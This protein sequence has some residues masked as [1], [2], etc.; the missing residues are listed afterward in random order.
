MSEDNY[1]KIDNSSPS[2]SSSIN[3]DY[4]FLNK[5]IQRLIENKTIKNP[6]K[7][8]FIH[9][10]Y[11]GDGFVRICKITFPPQ[12]HEFRIYYNYSIYKMKIFTTSEDI[13]KRHFG[14]SD[15]SIID[16]LAD[17]L[18]NAKI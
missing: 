14:S 3:N 10:T 15:Y 11:P 6:T 5:H 17:E 2:Y 12:N 4:K 7:I 9:R 13:N 1:F 8:V 16:L 18:F